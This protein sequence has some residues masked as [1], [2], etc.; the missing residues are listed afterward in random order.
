[1]KLLSGVHYYYD[2]P[3]PPGIVVFRNEL[4]VHLGLAHQDPVRFSFVPQASTTFS[5]VTGQPTVPTNEVD[6]DN[7]YFEQVWR[8]GIRQIPGVD[9]FRTPLDSLISG[10]DYPSYQ[11][12]SFNFNFTNTAIDVTIDE[13]RENTNTKLFSLNKAQQKA[14]LFETTN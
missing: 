1:M 3:S 5:R 2:A 11:N 6:V 10:V 14:N 7:V 4:T 13:Q 8:N 12:N 9:Y